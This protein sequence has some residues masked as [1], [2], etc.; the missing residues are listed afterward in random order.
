M[1]TLNSKKP[2]IIFLIIAV[3]ILLVFI[4]PFKFEYKI[5]SQGQVK[6]AKEWTIFKGTDASISSVLTDHLSGI[7]TSYTVAQFVRGDVVQFSFSDGIKAGVS[8][9]KGDTIGTVYSSELDREIVGLKNSIA[10]TRSTLNINLSGEKVS[11]IKQEQER[12]NYALRQTEEHKKIL[13]RLKSLFERGLVSQEE[14]EIAQGTAALNEINIAISKAALESVESGEKPELINY[15]NAQ[16]TTLEKELSVLEKRFNG[17]TM[18]TPISGT[19]DRQANNDTLFVLNDVSDFV[20]II[21]V[22]ILEKKY[23]NIPLK[24]DVYL[25][26]KKQEIS[27][28]LISIDNKVRLLNGTQ[29]IVGSAKL[30]GDLQNLMPGMMVECYL[31]LGSFSA[32]EYLKIVWERLVN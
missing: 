24:V 15:F 10:L 26:N 1:L 19:I 29:V 30:S 4:L 20:I 11:L 13:S 9:N 31:N 8:V 3:V 12:L 6:P 28:E 5:Q 7:N 14:Y 27:A 23:I 25:N 2:L 32:Y 22:N 16:I 21:P 18:I 17:L